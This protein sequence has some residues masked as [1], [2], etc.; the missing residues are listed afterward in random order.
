MAE[1]DVSDLVG[2]LSSPR[3][4]LRRPALQLLLPFTAASSPRR[5]LLQSKPTVARLAALARA[6]DPTEAHDAV[7]ALINLAESEAVRRQL[8]AEEGFL[9]WMMQRISVRRAP[10]GTKRV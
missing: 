9:R 8:N 4:D 2:F 10:T 1:S 7:K 6:D 3:D 5:L